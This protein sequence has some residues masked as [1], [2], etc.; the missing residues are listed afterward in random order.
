MDREQLVAD[1]KLDEGLKLHAYQDILGY[2]TIGHGRLIDERKGGGI[3][4]AEAEILLYGDVERVQREVRQFIPWYPDQPETVQRAL[5]N[6]A[7]QMGL[8]GLLGFR[9]TLELI[10]QGHYYEAASEAMDSKWAKQ[11]PNRAE[12]VARLIRLGNLHGAIDGE[13]S[14][15]R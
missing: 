6:M 9:K 10:R 5:C 12:R 13:L 1:L 2:W 14:S 15:E 4:K 8:K 3:T 7:Y 11:T